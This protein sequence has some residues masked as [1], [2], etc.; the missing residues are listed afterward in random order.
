MWSSPQHPALKTKQSIADKKSA[1]ALDTEMTLG[2]AQG[3]ESR[4]SVDINFSL[5]QMPG[6]WLVNNLCVD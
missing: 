4:N 6:Q 1:I 5:I 3:L 2:L